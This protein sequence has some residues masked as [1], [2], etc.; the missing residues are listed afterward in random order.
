MEL[1]QGTEYAIRGAVFLSKLAPGEVSFTREMSKR[2]RIPST[3]LAKLLTSLA[4]AG[5]VESHRG[6]GGGYRLAGRA[7]RIRLLSIIEAVEGPLA[8]T[9]CLKASPSCKHTKACNLTK[10]F[11][12]AQ[13]SITE[14]LDGVTLADLANETDNQHNYK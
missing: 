2:L 5:I 4:R 10:I 11:Q 12:T 3:F 9:R 1:T 14:V 13:A 6:A 7:D 8:L